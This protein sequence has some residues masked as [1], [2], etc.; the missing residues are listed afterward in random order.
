MENKAKAV[1][2]LV[3]TVGRAG[4]LQSLQSLWQKLGD[5]TI[6]VHFLAGSN[7][8]PFTITSSPAM[9]PIYYLS[10]GDQ[11]VIAQAGTKWLGPEADQVLRLRIHTHTPCFHVLLIKKQGQLYFLVYTVDVCSCRFCFMGNETIWYS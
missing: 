3:Y 4:M 10:T 6:R 11:E 1:I 7:I 2:L 5:W 9:W 8:F